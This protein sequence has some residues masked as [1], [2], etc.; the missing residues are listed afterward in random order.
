MPLSDQVAL[1]FLALKPQDFAFSVYRLEIDSEDQSVPGTRFLPKDILPEGSSKGGEFIRY[2][3][4]LK[5]QEHF[6]KIKINA[7][8]NPGLTTEVLHQALTSRA[9]L[10]DL[11]AN[12][13]LPDK[14]F[15]REVAFVLNRHHDARE[16]MWLRAYDLRVLGRFGF[17]CNFAL[18]VPF[19]SSLT[20]KDRLELSLTHKNGR[21]NAD[22]FLDQYQK[23]GDFLRLYFASIQRLELHDGT[24]L[25]L[26]DKLSVIPSFTLSTRTYIFGNRREGKNQFFGLRDFSPFQ[27]AEPDARLVFV[28]QEADRLKSQDLFRALRG[29]TYST[30]PGMEKMFRTSIGK[31]NVAGI[32]VADFGCQELERVCVTLKERYPKERVLPVALVPMSKHST[33]E[34]TKNYYS[35][36]HV[37]LSHGLACQFVDRKRLD[38]RN[39]LKWSISNIALGL[40][41][42]M[43]GVPWKIKPSTEKCLIVGIGQAHSIV[44]DKIEKY[45]AYSVLTDS[46]GIYETIRVLGNSTNRREYLESLK[47]NLGR[48]LLS[49]K[50][51]YNSFVLHVTF[52][53][54]NEEIDAIHSLLEE[55]K[56]KDDVGCEFVAI[57]LNDHNSYFGFSTEHNSL[58]PYEGTVARLSKKDFLMWFSGVGLADS[59][60][61][62]NPERPVQ[63]HI[64]YPDRP[65]TDAE[66]KRLLQDAMNIAGANWRGF[67]AKSMPI[68][69][70]YARLIADYYAH[71]R[72]LN[73]PEVDMDNLPPWFL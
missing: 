27:S 2:T 67:N 10:T 71:F 43:G 23:V 15:I 11:A 44:E 69:V 39:A 6:E 47:T 28:F 35:A 50:N 65:L 48:V 8:T 4:S 54:K 9:K 3:V 25:D 40:F 33:D 64:L 73:L 30:F 32:E 53:M 1:S 70:Y 61:P 49:H 14:G 52:R 31:H 41:A 19:E 17:L 12:V 46:S 21:M 55:L 45:V 5:P 7:W 13:E 63:L 42:K 51:E 22:F 24:E 20:A 16:V 72:Q 56:E 60:A 38:D 37:F 66:L 34:E 36:K 59:K 26:D 62:K 57:K 58:V 29:G 68:S 18:R